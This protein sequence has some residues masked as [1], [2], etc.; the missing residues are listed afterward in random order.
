MG[1]TK[2]SK[3]QRKFTVFE[4]ELIKLFNTCNAC[5]S[6]R[7]VKIRSNG[8]AV[9]VAAYCTMCHNSTKWCSQPYIR[10]MPVGNLLLSAAILMSEMKV[11]PSEKNL[12]ICTHR[13]IFYFVYTS[14]LKRI[15]KLSFY[16]LIR[17]K[18]L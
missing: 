2:C 12:N 18:I 11:H 7:T 5:Q 6:P 8:S 9:H 15:G 10:Q 14:I 1:V 3:S 16:C 17:K 4:D 13:E